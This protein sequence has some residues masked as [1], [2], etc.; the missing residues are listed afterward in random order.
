M[1]VIIVHLEWRS[2]SCDGAV[3][4]AALVFGCGAA[5]GN[6]CEVGVH[7]TELDFEFVSLISSF[8]IFGLFNMIFIVIGQ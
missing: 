5:S 2:T 8:V 3:A 4:A 1:V 7:W 6:G